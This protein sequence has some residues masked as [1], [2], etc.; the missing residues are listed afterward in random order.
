MAM[1]FGARLFTSVPLMSKAKRKHIQRAQSAY[2]KS[3]IAGG[4]ATRDQANDM[5]RI[6]T[7]FAM[8]PVAREMGFTIQGLLTLCA[9]VESGWVR[10]GTSRTTGEN[11]YAM[12]PSFAHVA[13][14]FGRMEIHGT[15]HF[16]IGNRGVVFSKDAIAIRNARRELADQIVANL[17]S[18]RGDDMSRL[19]KAIAKR[20]MVPE[21][22]TSDDQPSGPVVTVVPHLGPRGPEA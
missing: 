7:H 13:D 16:S 2:A 3:T 18:Q 22:A 19:V 15:L 1:A 11:V 12:R 4:S 17:Q 8:A 10:I 9:T 14:G 6:A 20:H 21:V 5:V